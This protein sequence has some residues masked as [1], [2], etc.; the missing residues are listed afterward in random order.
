MNKRTLQIININLLVLIS[1]R[2]F[3]AWVLNNDLFKYIQLSFLIIIFFICIPL[4]FRYKGGFVFPVQLIVASMLIS[5]VVNYFTWGQSIFNSLIVLMP[6]TIWVFFFLLLHYK[7]QP[8]TIEKIVLFYGILYVILYLFQFINH[9]V[10]YFGWQEEIGLSRGV[11]RI[12]FPGG[13]VFYFTVFMALSKL[14]TKEKNRWLWIIFTVLGLLISIMQATRQVIATVLIIYILHFLRNNNWY[15][16]T[17]VVVCVVGLY[18]FLMNTDNRI[19]QGLKSDMERDSKLGENYIR[20][21]SAMFFLEEFS[22]TL[23]NKILGNGVPRATTSSYGDFVLSLEKKDRYYMV[24]VGLIGFYALFGIFAI[25]AY[26]IIWYKSF[27]IKL[28]PRFYY[29]KYYL[30]F[31]LITSLTSDFTFGHNFLI[32]TVFVIYIYHCQQLKKRTNRL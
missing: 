9:N 22:P 24:D 29:L 3:D 17:L 25:V 8:M 2:F 26:L 6:F 15:L 28:P 13:G 23:A 21:K 32:T 7:I 30:W 10:V 16:K 31:L 11:L 1:L 20:V 5:V 14:Q 19:V 12:F 27:T 18:F 4:I